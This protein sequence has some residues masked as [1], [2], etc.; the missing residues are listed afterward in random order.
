L[1]RKNRELEEFAYVVSHDLQEPLRTINIYTQLFLRRAEDLV[2]GQFRDYASF[3]Q[4][5]VNRMDRLIHDLLSYSRTVHADGAPGRASA[6][7]ALQ[8]AL[9]GLRPL[10]D[11]TA[12]VITAEPLPLVE[13]DESQLVQVF[14]NILSNAIKY[15]KSGE[16]ARVHISAT[17]KDDTCTIAIRDEGIGFHP[18]YST[19]IF[20]LFK[21]L[22]RD[23]YPGTG[24]GLAICKR[25][26]E[27]YGGTIRAESEAGVGSTFYFTLATPEE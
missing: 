7:A 11:D 19:R 6:G 8:A 27:R 23:Q 21:R 13:A 12:S 22:H 17:V 15:R 16:P 26:I 1:T 14:Q 25:I 2:D 5:G 24:L 9:E 20:G 10:I 4:N 18:E 3:I